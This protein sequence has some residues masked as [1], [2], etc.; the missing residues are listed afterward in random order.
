MIFCIVPVG[1]RLWVGRSNTT[2]LPHLAE[3]FVYRM[4]WA[5]KELYLRCLPEL[6]L[7]GVRAS[8]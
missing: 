5:G 6:D 8:V 7:S 2:R 4:C 1:G 3:P